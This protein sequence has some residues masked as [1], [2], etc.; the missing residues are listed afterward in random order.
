MTL[1]ERSQLSPTAHPAEHAG[2]GTAVVALLA[3]A[4]A[5]A[6]SPLFVKV[7]EAG[8]VATGFWRV[9]LALPFLWAWSL[10]G[11]RG[12]HARAFAADRRMMV[13]AGVLFAGDLAVWHWS[14]LLT[15][16]AN[17]TLLA[18]LAPIFVT[19][20]VW[21]FYRKRPGGAFLAGMAVALAGVAALLGGDFRLSGGELAGDC[22]GV[23]TA[24]FYAGYQL[25]VKQVRGRASTASVM[26]WSG[27]VTAALL[28]PIAMLSGEQ[29]LPATAAGWLKLL[30][31]ALI[32]QAAGQS[33]IA[34]AMAHLPA[35]FSSVGL[36]LQPVMAALFAWVLLGETLGGI[37]IAGGMAVLIGIYIAHGAD[38]AKRESVT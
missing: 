25:A 36:L 27:L 29:L 32:S 7:S 31:L 15:S 2:R 19:L 10:S 17:A 24:L 16:V 11:P 14:I 1:A 9:A 26:A 18:N 8:P 35:T 5:I 34:Y 28:L 3:G 30:G 20:T 37:E 13:A 38:A 21:L 23:L 4:V 33:L 6:V 22:L 12:A